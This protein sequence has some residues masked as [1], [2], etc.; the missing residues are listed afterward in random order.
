MNDG[1][2]LT[3]R[4]QRPLS[5]FTLNIDQTLTERVTGFYGPSGCGKTSLLE[6]IAG[7]ASNVHG[8]ITFCGEVW[9]DSKAKV[10]LPT[11]RRGI[12]Y[13]PQKGLLFPHLTVEQ[14]L[15]FGIG[16]GRATAR[17]SVLY[18]QVVQLLELRALLGRKPVSLSGGERQRVALGRALS[19]A[20]RLLLLDEPL[21]ALDHRLRYSIL[22]FLHRVRD[23]FSLPMIWVS[24]DA[25]EVQSL[26]DE[27]IVVRS[28]QAID[29]GRPVDLLNDPAV[30]SSHDETGFQNTLTCTI[31]AASDDEVVVSPGGDVS[32]SVA[33]SS[34]ACNVGDKALLTIPA[35][36]I[37]V[38]TEK[39]ASIS[40]RNVLEGAVIKQKSVGRA[41][42][43]TIK[44]GQEGPEL[45]VELTARACENLKIKVGD[46]LFALIKSTACVL[47]SA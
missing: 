6:S 26:C 24:H 42:I 37:L 14:N 25:V 47:H 7:V 23:E 16:R 28:G 32:L 18:D 35:R 4:I 41:V 2:E 43:L 27:L 33:G 34:S 22:P 20:P 17:S 5:S 3:L 1:F 30:A 29:R 8:R 15:R 10:C 19:S 31:E 11:Q 44:L 36:S 45:A 9:L 12:G 46:H 40:A 38:A 39:P 21:S 13:V